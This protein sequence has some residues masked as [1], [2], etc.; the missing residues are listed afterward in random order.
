MTLYQAQYEYVKFYVESNARLQASED[1]KSYPSH[2][3]KDTI[4]DPS[5]MID[6][7]RV[8]DSW[9]HGRKA[10][11]VFVQVPAQYRMALSENQRIE[12]IEVWIELYPRTVMELLRKRYNDTAI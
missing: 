6:V 4:E 11:L 9:K 5:V 10:E 3:I 12:L 1:A 7:L 8:L 2:K